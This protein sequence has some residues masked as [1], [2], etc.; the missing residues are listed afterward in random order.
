MGTINNRKAETG[1]GGPLAVCIND[2]QLDYGQASS[3]LVRICFQVR[4]AFA[5]MRWGRAAA[6]A[7]EAGALLAEKKLPTPAKHNSKEKCSAHREL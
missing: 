2:C 5:E 6:E 3:E 7:F 4:C 1:D